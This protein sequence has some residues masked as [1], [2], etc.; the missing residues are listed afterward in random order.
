[1]AITKELWAAYII[2][3]L[4]KGNEFL[5]DAFNADEYVLNGAVVHIPQAGAKP[6][7][8]KNRSSFPAASVQRTDTDITYPLDN[9][10]TDPTLILEAEKSELSYDKMDSV[11]GEHVET[12]RELVGDDML[13][14]WAPSVATQIIRTTGG[15]VAAHLDSAIGNRK[16]FLKEDLKAA[17]KLMNKH[18]IPQE[19]RYAIISSDMIDQLL[20]DSDLKARDGMK[21]GELNLPDGVITKLYGFYIRERS[22]VLVYNNAGTPVVKALGAAAA[23]TDNDAVLCYQK[24]CIERSMGT[25]TM[26]E[27]EGDPNNYGDIYSALVKMGGRKRRSDG[28][29]VVAI[30]QDASA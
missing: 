16:K 7:A 24:N 23:A 13:I 25:V 14:K 26:F 28:K 27:N 30:V 15:A 12:L 19:D 1:M 4:F 3:N 6:A 29:G 5:N 18:N 17:R 9:Y 10:T 11:M 22:T 2:G 20:D 8:T 21:G